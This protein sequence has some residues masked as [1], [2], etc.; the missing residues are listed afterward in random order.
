MSAK[1]ELAGKDERIAVLEREIAEAQELAEAQLRNVERLSLKAA[2][3]EEAEA[4]LART[5]KDRGEAWRRVGELERQL[6]EQ[7]VMLRTLAEQNT[8]L[9][10][11]VGVMGIGDLEAEVAS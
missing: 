7:D 5:H 8:T 6:A 2:R 3:T 11:V 10:A 9:L 4:A 1:K